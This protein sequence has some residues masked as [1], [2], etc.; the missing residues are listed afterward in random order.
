MY[1]LAFISHGKPYISGSNSKKAVK[2]FLSESNPHIDA[3]RL[4]D[5]TGWCD[6]SDDA[7]KQI[8]NLNSLATWVG[9]FY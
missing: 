7:W 5:G 1:H 4:H 2:K 8:D 3:W 6:G 9:F